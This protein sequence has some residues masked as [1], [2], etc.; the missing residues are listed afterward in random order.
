MSS[1][2]AIPGVVGVKQAAH[3]TNRPGSTCS[4]V[5]IL[6]RNVRARFS[7]PMGTVSVKTFNLSLAVISA[8]AAVDELCGGGGGGCEDTVGLGGVGA[9]VN[10]EEGRTLTL[11]LRMS[12]ISGSVGFAD[13]GDGEAG[14]SGGKMLAIS[15]I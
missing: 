13:L 6:S 3:K 11:P 14:G 9:D 10:V 5:F 7:S 15:G 8:S 2:R 12:I 1:I 4:T